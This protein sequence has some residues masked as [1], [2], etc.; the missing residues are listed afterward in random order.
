M[1]PRI[2]AFQSGGVRGFRGFYDVLDE[3]AL[4]VVYEPAY[5]FLVE[6]GDHR[7]LFDTGMNFRLSREDDGSLGVL[8]SNADTLIP[9]LATVG[10]TPADLT[11]VVLSHMHNDHSGGLEY[12]QSDTPVYVGQDELAFARNPPSYQSLLFDQEDL[13]YETNWI[14]VKGDLDL[15]GDGRITVIATPGHTPGHQVLRVRLDESTIVLGGDASYLATKMR[16]RRVP[17][18]V[19]NPDLLVKSWEMLEQ[20]ERDD[21]ARL[22]FSHELDY[23]ESKPLPPLDWYR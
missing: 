6:M 12:I 23:E 3:R 21:Q 1:A 8:L 16:E 19:W 13:S 14:P 5:F 20:L 2:F 4:E 15:L 7:I 17:G 9:K 18:V 11:G 10:V 22:V